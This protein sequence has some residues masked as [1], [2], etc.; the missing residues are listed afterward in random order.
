M[1]KDDIILSII[2]PVY[3]VEPYLEQCLGAILQCNLSYCEIILALG[4]SSD[5]SNEICLDYEHMFPFIHT[6]HQSGTGLS[7]AR[8]CAMDVVQGE[9]LLFLDS[10]DYVDSVRLNDLITNIRDKTLS[11]DVIVTDFYRLDQRTNCL[12]PIFQI[13]EDTPIQYGMEFLPTMLCRRQCFWNVWRYV[14]RRS[15]LER[16]GIRFIENRLSEDVDF[17]AKVFLAEPEI[18]FSHSPYYIYVVGR[19]GSLM[20]CPDIKRLSDTVFILRQAIKKMHTSSFPYAPQM[21]AQFQF[22]YILNLALTVEIDPEDRTEA[23]ALYQDWPHVL[24]ESIDPVVRCAALLLRIL[25]TKPIAYGLHV[26]KC[27]RRWIKKYMLRGKFRND[28]YQDAVP[29]QLCRRR[30]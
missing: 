25:G 19:G 12:L 11:P 22:E 4:N 9:Y 10:D 24:S 21:I 3:N 5:R 1:I 29:H 13:G 14:Y 30:Q 2:I 16:H 26:I 17:T 6:L 7:N 28:Y 18:V 8:N 23:L 20:D 27:P 15:F